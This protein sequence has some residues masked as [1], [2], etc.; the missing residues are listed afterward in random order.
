MIENQFF[1]KILNESYEDDYKAWKS[2]DDNWMASNI[3]AKKDIYNIEKS[4]KW[5]K[6]YLRSADSLADDVNY[7][8]NKMSKWATKNVHSL[9][10]LFGALIKCL[11]IS[12][13]YI[14]TKLIS[15]TITLSEIPAAIDDQK[16]K[17]LIAEI[18]G[19]LSKEGLDVEDLHKK[20]ISNYNKENV[21]FEIGEK[22]RY[23]GRVAT[24]I[25]P[26]PNDRWQIKY[27]DGRRETVPKSAIKPYKTELS[28]RKELYGEDN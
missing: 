26:M 25:K 4:H 23:D 27:N 5:S 17:D 12:A 3:A 15:G 11:L 13:P 10:S 7:T 6:N 18:V 16:A 1:D 19:K 2:A 22:I 9:P 21:K 24:L 8:S 14:V 28:T 20:M